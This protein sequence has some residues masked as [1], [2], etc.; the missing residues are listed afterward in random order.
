MVEIIV[1]REGLI[2]GLNLAGK[3]YFLAFRLLFKK[4]HA[5]QQGKHKSN[6]HFF[7]IELNYDLCEFS[8][9]KSEM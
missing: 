3:E 1:F 5:D 6:S 9:C 8:V 7:L 2:T 4:N